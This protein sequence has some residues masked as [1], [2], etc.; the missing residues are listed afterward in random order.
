M[1]K[2]IALDLATRIFNE[3]FKQSKKLYGRS[4]L[5]GEYNV[6]PETI[7]RAVALLRDMDVV[8]V[9][10]G[11][12]VYI[13]SLERS[14]SFIEKYHDKESITSLRKDINLLKQE[15][16]KIE[17]QINDKTNKIIDYSDKLKNTNPIN[18][19]EVKLNS[20][21][22]LIGKTISDSKFCKTLELLSLELEEMMV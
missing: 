22:H 19:I 17:K 14:Y 8:E 3:E 6:S 11:S 9:K 18:P 2:K 15:K 20:N 10:H 21:S 13:K 16:E 5:A 7:R 12:G 4:V 1:Y